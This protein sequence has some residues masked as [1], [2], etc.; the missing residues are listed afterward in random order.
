MTAQSDATASYYSTV[1]F[2]KDGGSE[3]VTI[4]DKLVQ[5]LCKIVHVDSL[6][7]E[8]RMSVDGNGTSYYAQKGAE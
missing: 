8:Y 3:L 1:L 7:V 6:R 5:A 4:R 2:L